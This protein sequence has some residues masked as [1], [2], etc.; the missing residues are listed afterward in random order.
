MKVSCKKAFDDGHKQ[1]RKYPLRNGEYKLKETLYCLEEALDEIGRIADY[2][3]TSRVK[4]CELRHCTPEDMGRWVKNL[5][6]YIAHHLSYNVLPATLALTG[7]GVPELKVRSLHSEAV[8][9]SDALVISLS[10]V[11]ARQTIQALVAEAVDLIESVLNNAR[12]FM[13]TS[14]DFSHP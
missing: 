6:Q 9:R 2:K 13:K 8:R 3:R 11:W 5:P 7:D 1:R 12:P 14:V 10:S 4:G